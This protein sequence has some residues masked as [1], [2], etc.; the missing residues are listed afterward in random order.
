MLWNGTFKKIASDAWISTLWSNLRGHVIIFIW[1]WKNG[2]I[3]AQGPK[4]NKTSPLSFLQLEKFE[5]TKWACFIHIWPQGRDMAILSFFPQFNSGPFFWDTLYT[6][7]RLY[8]PSH[9]NVL[10]WNRPNIKF[11]C[12]AGLAWWKWPLKCSLLEQKWQKNDIILGKNNNFRML[13]Q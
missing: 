9:P 13:F 1:K 2:H 4:M 11:T 10:R 8:Q 3:S 7:S 12:S 6:Y 5:K